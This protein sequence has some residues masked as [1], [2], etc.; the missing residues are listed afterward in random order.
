M[1]IGT[2]VNSVQPFSRVQLFVTPCQVSLSITNSW[3]LPK[4]KSIEVVM[5]SNHLISCCPLRLPLQ[6]FPA[7]GSF[8]MSQLFSTGGQNIGV[9]ASISVFP[10]NIQDLSPLGWT[11]W[12]CFQS[13]GLSRVFSTP[14]FKSINSSMLS[15]LYS[16]TL[17][18]IHDY[19]KKH[20]LD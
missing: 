15:F 1:A 14:K 6:S 5:P 10:M 3:S 19:W 2:S 12:I 20:S 18:S 17:T 8:Q 9:S 13:K 16:P 11:C 4:L 7:S